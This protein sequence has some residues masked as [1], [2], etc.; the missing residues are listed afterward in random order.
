MTSGM[1]PGERIS[2]DSRPR[3]QTGNHDRLQARAQTVLLELRLGPRDRARLVRGTG[4]ARADRVGE[5]PDP[6]VRGW[7]F[8]RLGDER[9]GARER[10]IARGLG[11]GGG[12]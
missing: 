7:H 12:A 3:T 4:K 10:R 2:A 1:G 9:L 6:L 8:H 11:A 5:G